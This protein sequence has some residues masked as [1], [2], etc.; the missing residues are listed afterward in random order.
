MDLEMLKVIFAFVTTMTTIILNYLRAK[1]KGKKTEARKDAHAK[2]KTLDFAYN[3]LRKALT[4]ADA[5]F[6]I[7]AADDEGTMIEWQKAK[8]EIEDALKIIERRW[9]Q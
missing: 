2:E 7:I 8:R 1:E 6:R 9:T 5:A 3:A 4:E